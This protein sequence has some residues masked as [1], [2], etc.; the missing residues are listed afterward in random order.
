[1]TEP[2]LLPP[3]TKPLKIGL[4]VDGPVVPHTIADLAA[5]AQSEPSMDLSYLIVQQLP[6][7][8]DSILTQLRRVYTRRGGRALA[9]RIL[10][11]LV[12]RLERFHLRHTAHAAYFR[13]RNIADVVEHAIY[14]TP[15]VS[16]SGM[17]YRYGTRDLENIRAQQFDLLIRGG[18]GILRGDVLTAARLGIL[19]FHHGDSR[20]YRGGPPGFWEVYRRDPKTGFIIQRLSDDLDGGPVLLHGSFPTGARWMANEAEVG[21]RSSQYLKKLLLLI[22]RSGTL[23]TPEESMPYSGQLFRAPHTTILLRYMAH[24]AWR[25]V[26]YLWRTRMLGQRLRW[27]IAF[28]RKDWKQLTM[29][30]AYRVMNPKG[31]YFADPFVMTREG[32]D[33]CFVEDFDDVSGRAVISVLA[34][35]EESARFLGRAITE[36]FHL[37]FPYIFEHEGRLYMVPESAANQDIR[38]YECVDFPLHWRHVKTLMRD[39]SAA[40]TMVFRH[41]DRW[42]MLTNINPMGQGEHCSELYAFY[43]D[44][45][46]RGEWK[47]HAQNPLYIDP[48]RAR[49]GGLL[50]DGSQLYRVGQRYGFLQYG[51]GA[52][53]HRIDTLTPEQFKETACD[54][55]M[56]HFFPGLRGTHHLHSNGSVTAFDMAAYA[57]P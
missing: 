39:V 36:S 18:S 49:N 38:L 27:S 23:P 53:I 7:A 52:T 11:E 33:Y 56:P 40:D 4:I 19:S 50:K 51:A 42:W 25:K 20:R 55:L 41:E 31:R 54:T 21:L 17:V 3:A 43:S 13:S 47:P 6:S 8:E 32:K 10:L 1:M 16:P 45:L 22:A 26:E 44:D 34:L 9:A 29:R 28:A 48:T 46:L 37:S 2:A 30:S 15:E 57:K 35:E 12:T 5:W 14:V 24:V